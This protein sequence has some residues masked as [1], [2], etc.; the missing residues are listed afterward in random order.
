MLWHRLIELHGSELTT[1]KWKAG[2]TYFGDKSVGKIDQF[3]LPNS[4]GGES[5]NTAR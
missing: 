3:I 2:H 1:M 5:S 4:M